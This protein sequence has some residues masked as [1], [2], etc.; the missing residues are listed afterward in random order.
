MARA[1]TT[2][3]VETVKPNPDK[4]VEISDA[5]CT[6][7]FLVIQPSG[8]KGWA[9]RFRFEGRP[10]KLTLGRWPAMGLAAA[11]E[12]AGAALDEVAHG[13]NP[14]AAKQAEKAAQQDAHLNERDKVKTLVEQFDRR[15]LSALKSGRQARAFLDR[16]VVAAW[17]ER[18]VQTITKR[19]IVDLLD[20]VVDS[21]RA[22]TANRVLAH[23]KKFFNW[24]VERDVLTAS[25][26]TSVKPPVKEVSRDRVL[27]DDEIVWLWTAC[28]RAGEP[29]GPM[30]KLLL[31]TGQRLNEVAQM[32]EAEIA[33]GDVWHLSS[34][35]TKNGRAHDVPLSEAARTVLAEK[36]RVSGKAGY[37]FTTTG[38]TPVSGFDRALKT[39]S[40][41]MAKV[42]AEARSD[43]AEPV[44]IPHWTFHDLRRTLA[45]GLARMGVPLRVTEAVLNHVSGSAAGIVSVYQRHDFAPEKAQA[46]E[47]WGRRVMALVDGRDDA[48]DN[49]VKIAARGGAQ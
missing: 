48:A 17:G 35:R 12:A 44:E 49:V 37:I 46:I 31:L 24:L 15:H 1:L 34:A 42:A 6:G 13:R 41:E 18:D 22:T 11:R 2:R 20:Q 30:A 3:T 16:F 32:T 26:A 43:G 47:A 28:D 8:S 5:G 29:F 33:G 27:S 19:D 7:L 4:R 40:A 36:P 10:T 39:I 45:T 14:A 23:T 25:P 38:E 21:G 9:L